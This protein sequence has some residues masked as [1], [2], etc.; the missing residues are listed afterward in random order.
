MRGGDRRAPSKGGTVRDDGP[1]LL[2]R[3]T[4]QAL[5]LAVLLALFARTF[6]VQAFRIP[7]SS[8]EHTLLAGDHVLVNKFVFGPTHSDWERRWLPVRPVDRADIVVFRDP[9]D[10]FRD[11]VKRCAA[12]P[13]ERVRLRHK[14][15]YV[16]GVPLEEPWAHFADPQSFPDTPFLDQYVYY[17]Q[18]DHLAPIRVPPGHLFLLGDNRDFSHDSRFWGS[19]QAEAV[20]GRPLLVYWSFSLEEGDGEAP[21]SGESAWV[22]FLQKTRWSRILRPVR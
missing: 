21:S 22:D 17:Q 1:R 12:L 18:R 4:A 6:L 19:L 14:Q 5:M 16:D 13:G 15:V 8:M 3:E 2:A 9:S 10:P 20:R 7:S 11:F